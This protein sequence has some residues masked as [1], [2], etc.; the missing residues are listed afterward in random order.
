MCCCTAPLVWLAGALNPIRYAVVFTDKYFPNAYKVIMQ[1]ST[2]HESYLT[3][4]QT[5]QREA[6][7]IL[8]QMNALRRLAC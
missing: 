7:A 8:A 1:A 2:T 6:I 3:F 5:R 4:D